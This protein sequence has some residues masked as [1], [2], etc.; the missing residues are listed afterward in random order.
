MVVS[1]W[2]SVVKVYFVE[3]IS[4]IGQDD[5]VGSRQVYSLVSIIFWLLSVD[6]Y[7][8]STTVDSSRLLFVVCTANGVG[9]LH[10]GM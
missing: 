8:S 1:G 2:L 3:S 6:C 4:R 7:C 10:S 5:T 9:L